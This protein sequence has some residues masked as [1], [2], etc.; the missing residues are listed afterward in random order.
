MRLGAQ[1]PLLGRG[2]WRFTAGMNAL[3]PLLLSR[4]K[5]T[6]AVAESL[7]CGRLQA[8]IGAESGA[9]DYF[10]GGITA[11]NLE[12]KVALLGVDRAAAKRVACVSADVAEQMAR[13]VRER[14]GSDLALA[15]TGY[16]EPSP[17]A[18]VA[19]P[20]AF[21]AL[22]HRRGRRLVVRSG[23]IEC[24]GARRVEAQTIV[25]EAVLG[26]LVAYLQAERT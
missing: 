19:N 1:I 2:G 23:R 17:A 26:E 15:T 3:R 6:L 18:Q 8:A 11:Y 24:P 21:W 25:A 5:L 14:F 20:F 9:S 16:A 22:V 4:P 10:L 13:G 7:T 12:Q